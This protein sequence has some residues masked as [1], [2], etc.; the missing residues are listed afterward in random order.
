MLSTIFWVLTVIAAVLGGGGAY[1]LATSQYDHDGLAQSTAG[2]VAL[3]LCVPFAV[4][5]LVVRAFM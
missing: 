1:M 3:V 5:A 2:F 4:C